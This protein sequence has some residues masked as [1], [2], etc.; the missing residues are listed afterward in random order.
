M[1]K[2]LINISP[3]NLD[4]YSVFLL[5]ALLCKS[6]GRPRLDPAWSVQKRTAVLHTGRRTVKKVKSPRPGD[7]HRVD[8]TGSRHCGK[9]PNAQCDW[10]GVP[11]LRT[12]ETKLLGVF[13]KLKQALTN[14]A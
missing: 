5:Y 13:R 2:N 14:L 3:L 1:F 7:S 4:F 8:P 9:N 10:R 12:L 11:G 6:K